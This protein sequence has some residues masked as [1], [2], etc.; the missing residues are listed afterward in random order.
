MIYPQAPVAPDDA[1]TQAEQWRLKRGEG[2]LYNLQRGDVTR[3]T[4]G[5][6]HAL[7]YEVEHDA[8]W[9]V[10]GDNLERF[11]EGEKMQGEWIGKTLV[12]PAARTYNS[13]RLIPEAE[14]LFSLYHST[15]DATIGRYDRADEIDTAFWSRSITDQRPFR[16][17]SAGRMRGIR[18]GFKLIGKERLRAAFLAQDMREIP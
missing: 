18:L 10:R 14:T 2:V 6:V 9:V 17:G 3:M 16:V 7:L 15:N 1:L 8:L 4:Q 5:N 12:V 11:N 13:A